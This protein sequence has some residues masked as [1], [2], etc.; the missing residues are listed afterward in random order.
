MKVKVEME[1]SEEDGN[2]TER[3][4]SFLLHDKL[5]YAV[6]EFRQYL[7]TLEKYDYDRVSKLTANEIVDE[8][9]ARLHQELHDILDLDCLGV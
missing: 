5:T 6:N 9:R 3:A 4:A 7:R 1:F 2:A 8:I